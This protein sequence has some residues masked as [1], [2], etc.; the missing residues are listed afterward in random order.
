[1]DFISFNLF[2]SECES[3]CSAAAPGGLGRNASSG[4]TLGGLYAH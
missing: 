1:M 3:L 4:P 2:D